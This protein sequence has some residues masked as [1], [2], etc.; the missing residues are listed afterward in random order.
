M[1]GQATEWCA[2]VVGVTLLSFV[3]GAAA[4]QVESLSDQDAEAKVAPQLARGV[5]LYSKHCALCHGARGEGYAADKAPALGNQ[6]FLVSVNDEFLRRA[7]ANGHPGTPRRPA[8]RSGLI[9]V[10]QKGA[11]DLYDILIEVLVGLSD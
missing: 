1:K 9:V 5:D 6:D 2:F 3:M 10:A 4:A 8:H 7:I 11:N